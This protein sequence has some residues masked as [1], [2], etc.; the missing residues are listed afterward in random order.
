M[1]AQTVRPAPPASSATVGPPSDRPLWPSLAVVAVASVLAFLAIFAIWLNRQVLD[2]DNWTTASTRMLDNPEIRAQTAGYLTDQLYDNVDVEGQIRDVL[3]PQAQALAGPAASFL[4]GQV[5]TRLRAALARPDVQKLW[6][7]ANRDAHVL[8]LRALRGGGPIVS[9]DNGVVVLDLKALLAESERRSGFG[10][11]VADALPAGAAHLTI[12]RS[13]QLRFAQNV[14]RILKPLAI[15]LVVLSL[16]LAGLAMFMARAFRRRIL[17]AYGLGLIVAGV[18]A[19]LAVK[20]AG[21]GV[22]DSVA[23][24]DEVKPVVHDVWEIYTTLFRQAA[25]AAVA[26]GI[27]IVGCAWLAGPTAAAVAVRR[28]VAPYLRNP[29]LAYGGLAV[30]VVVVV[31]WWQPTPATRNPVTAVI[32]VGLLAAGFEFLRRQTAR[33]FPPD[34]PSPGAAAP[35]P[36]ESRPPAPVA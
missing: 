12:L 34:A 7:N 32:L 36:G 21:S 22:V 6:M 30:L 11:R 4:R 1:T 31:L 35:A 28:T 25:V 13:H 24:T 5:E 10:G 27:V 9:T 19:L 2:T 20:A 16:A 18:A 8:L 23:R 26:Y 33:E 17:R 15:L 29:L 14:A 3:P